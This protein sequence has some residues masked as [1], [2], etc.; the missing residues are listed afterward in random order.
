MQLLIDT[1]PSQRPRR[2][3]DAVDAEVDAFN[4][5]FEELDIAWRWDRD[6]LAD[7][8]QGDDRAKVSA[9]LRER[10]AH[11]LKVYDAGFIVDLIVATKARWGIQQQ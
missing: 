9:Y 1:I 7:F 4:A 2:Q 6:V 11:L 10:G 3:R 8:G 5:A